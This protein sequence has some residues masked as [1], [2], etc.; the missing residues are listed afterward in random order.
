[1]AFYFIKYKIV[2]N[3][4]QTTILEG[5]MT[6]TNEPISDRDTYLQ[7]TEGMI[8]KIINNFKQRES[9]QPNTQVLFESFSRLD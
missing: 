6:F 3:S 5:N 7:I 2:S 9:Y 8:K 1:M 4:N